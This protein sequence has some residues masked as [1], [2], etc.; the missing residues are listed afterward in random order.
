MTDQMMGVLTR[1]WLDCTTTK[2]FTHV[3]SDNGIIKILEYTNDQLIK[4]RFAP[5]N[6]HE[7]IEFLAPPP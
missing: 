6:L 1:K 4:S 7:F 2:R 5:T 3:L